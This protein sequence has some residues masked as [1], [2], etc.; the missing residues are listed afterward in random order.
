LKTSLSITDA[1]EH[2]FCPKFTYYQLVLGLRQYEEKQGSVEA[3]RV[4]HSRHASTNLTYIPRKLEGRKL[5]DVKL[6]SQIHMFSGKIDEAIETREEVTIIER[7]Y[8]DYV[9]IGTTIRTQLG[10]LSILLEENLKKKA[11]RAI[12]VFERT[13]RDEIQVNIT[14]EMRKMALSVLQETKEVLNSGLCP[15]A[16]YSNRCITCSYR[17]ICDIG[18]LRGEG[19]IGNHR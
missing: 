1:V 4:Y 5:V 6:F 17:K 15:V 19:E 11:R 18:S 9:N 3:G 8:S 12:V 10:L 7:K 2:A 14:E 13:R 16:Q